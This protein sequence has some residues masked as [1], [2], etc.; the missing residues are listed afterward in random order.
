MRRN[1]IAKNLHVNRPRIVP[2]RRNEG[3]TL[4]DWEDAGDRIF[5]TRC[6]QLLEAGEVPS[7]HYVHGHLACAACGRNVSECC[8]GETAS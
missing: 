4:A 8:S 6:H 3:P 1:P 5:C 2:G 7:A